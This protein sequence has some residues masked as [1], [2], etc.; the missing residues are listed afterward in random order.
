MKII[1]SETKRIEKWEQVTVIHKGK[2]I[3]FSVI[4]VNGKVK[5]DNKSN[6]ATSYLTYF[7]TVS[8]KTREKHFEIVKKFIED[9]NISSL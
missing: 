8:E 9:K 7:N 1:S 4:T 5:G 6:F 2:K 3:A